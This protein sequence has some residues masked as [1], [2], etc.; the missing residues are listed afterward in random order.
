MK[1][2]CRLR[3]RTKTNHA[4]APLDGTWLWIFGPRVGPGVEI[5]VVAGSGQAGRDFVPILIDRQAGDETIV[6]RRSIDAATPAPQ[7]SGSDRYH[8]ALALK[9]SRVQA[10][11]T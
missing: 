3:V 4:I 2:P 9:E 6:A 8:Q 11:H 10:R 7:R 1:S 5:N